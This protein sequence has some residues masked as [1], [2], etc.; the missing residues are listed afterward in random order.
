M[1]RHSRLTARAMPGSASGGVGMYA[2]GSRNATAAAGVSDP[3]AREGLRH[4]RVSADRGGERGG[5]GN[6]K[7]SKPGA[8]VQNSTSATCSKSKLAAQSADEA[9]STGPA[10]S[11]AA[12][13]SPASTPRPQ[14]ER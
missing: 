10:S 2:S 14:S 4:Q 13:M 12:C 1:A 6:V 5:D 3:A 7:G 9:S 8:R 11:S